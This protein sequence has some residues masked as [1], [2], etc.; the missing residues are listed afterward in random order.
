MD[1]E[2]ESIM[3]LECTCADIKINRWHV[4]M[5]GKKRTSYNKL[6]KKIKAELPELYS[7]LGLNFSNPYSKDTFE[8][9]SHYILTHSATEYFIRK[10]NE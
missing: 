3:E 7:Y 10:N 9:D 8:T 5:A 2:V 1:G 4:L 6:V